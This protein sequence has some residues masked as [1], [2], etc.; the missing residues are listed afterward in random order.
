MAEL[1]LLH[2]ELVELEL[3]SCDATTLLDHMDRDGDGL[4][5]FNELVA[6][7]EGLNKAPSASTTALASV[8]P[9]AQTRSANSVTPPAQAAPAT[10]AKPP[11]V[12]GAS[13]P[14]VVVAYAELISGTLPAGVDPARKELYLDDKEFRQ[15]FACEKQAFAAL[16]KWKRDLKKKELNLF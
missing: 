4:V 14:D 5:Q 12:T 11:A 3:I 13:P 7:L 6:W 16:P 10:T 15:L 1:R 9:V 2:A 8:A